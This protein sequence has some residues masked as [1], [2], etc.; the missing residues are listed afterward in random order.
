MKTSKRVRDWFITAFPA[1]SFLTMPAAALDI[2]PNSIKYLDCI[3]TAQGYI[4]RDFQEVFLPEGAINNGRVVNYD[5]FVH[6]LRELKHKSKRKFAF[7][8]IPENALYVYTLRLK[9]RLHTQA[10]MQ[11]IEFSFNEHVP[12]PLNE[13]IYDF[14]IV[15]MTHSAT[16]VSVT[17]APKDVIDGYVAAL[18]DAGFQPRVVELEAYA[19]ARS[20]AK[21]D[22]VGVEMIIDIGYSRAGIIITK[23]GIPIFSVTIAGGSKNISIVLEECKKQYTFWDTRTNKKGRRIERI[24]N[25]F[26]TGGTSSAYISK[27]SEAIGRRV[28][29]A[30]VWQNLFDTDDYIPTIDADKAQSMATLAGLLILNKK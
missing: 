30:N 6:S 9:G 28:Y 24:T 20:I 2:S 10:I 15:G 3:Y 14:D 27:I 5:A 26:V 11:Q 4:P 7:V 8:A 23:H 18:Y 21:A 13:A 16:V 25:V 1:P 29:L 22:K 17:A 19:V 12:L